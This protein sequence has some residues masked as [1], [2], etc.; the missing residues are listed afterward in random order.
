MFRH[1][2]SV[3]VSLRGSKTGGNATLTVESEH[4]GED[5]DTDETLTDRFERIVTGLS[6]QLRSTIDRDPEAGRYAIDIAVVDRGDRGP[7]I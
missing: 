4:L 7:S 1:A 2:E 5:G 6:R 3:A